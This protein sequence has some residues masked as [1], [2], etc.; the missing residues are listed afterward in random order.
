MIQV[1]GNTVVALMETSMTTCLCGGWVHN[2]QFRP[3]VLSYVSIDT[4]TV[5]NLSTI[6]KW[7]WINFAT[8]FLQKH[9]FGSEC[10]RTNNIQVLTHF[11][12]QFTPI[13]PPAGYITND[14]YGFVLFSR[15]KMKANGIRY[16]AVLFH[17]LSVTWYMGGFVLV[18]VC[19]RLEGT[20][21]LELSSVYENS[22]FPSAL[23]LSTSYN[24]KRASS[25]FTSLR[26]KYT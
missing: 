10:P 17:M 18:A 8:L 25:P 14:V 7:K 11:V 12:P 2:E 9:K 15:T 22:V 6:E 19:W 4:E 20:E 3:P 21:V 1:P 24:T 13:W 5:T 16:K 23:Y 26:M